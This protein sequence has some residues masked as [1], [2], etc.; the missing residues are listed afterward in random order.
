MNWHLYRMDDPNTWPEV[1][2]PML[3]YVEESLVICKWDNDGEYFIPDDDALSTYYSNV[4]ECYYAYIGYV[5][6]GYTVGKAKKCGV[7]PDTHCQYQDDGYCFDLPRHI[8]CKHAIERNEYCLNDN[9]RI[10][11]EFDEE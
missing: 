10:W 9:K 11:K 1:D 8:T 5:P 3:V 7:Y 2:C 6:N 4:F